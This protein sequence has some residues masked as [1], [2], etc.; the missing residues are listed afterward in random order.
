MH[1]ECELGVG[2][3]KPVR[4][5]TPDAAL[6]C[7]AGYTVANDYAVRD[8][9]ENYYRPNLRAKNRDAATLLGPWLVDAGDVP[10]PMDLELRTLVNGEVRQRGTTRDMI[11]D[12]WQLIAHLSRYLTLAPGDV[13]LT[14]TPQGVVNVDV[15]DEIVTEIDGIGRLVGYIDAPGAT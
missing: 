7:I 13:I 2:I 12:V 4:D 14:G 5:A 3:G 6:T 15:G 11:F 1:Y 8:H 10:D 9:L